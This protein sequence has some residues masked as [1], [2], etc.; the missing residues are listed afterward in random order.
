MIA[1]LRTV[2]TLVTAFFVTLFL[3][4]AVIIASLFGAEDKPGGL[5]DNAPRWWSKVLLL[6]AGVKVRVHG[7]ENAPQATP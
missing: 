2:L 1:F 6:A 5:F 3:G 4:S 7:L